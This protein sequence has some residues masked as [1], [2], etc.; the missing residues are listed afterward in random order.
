MAPKGKRA[1]G[2]FDPEWL[3]D[4]VAEFASVSSD[5]WYFRS[6]FAMKVMARKAVSRERAGLSAGWCMPVHVLQQTVTAITGWLLGR[7]SHVNENLSQ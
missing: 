6:I 1:V 7:L 2:V 3:T 5:G 4:F